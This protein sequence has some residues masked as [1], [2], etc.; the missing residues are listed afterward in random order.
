MK[1]SELIP[2]GERKA[3]VVKSKLTY[4]PQ[5]QAIQFADGEI[6]NWVSQEKIDFVKKNG[7]LYAGM[8]VHSTHKSWLMNNYEKDCVIAYL[9]SKFITIM[10][11]KARG[12]KVKIAV[13]IPYRKIGI[14]CGYTTFEWNFVSDD[15]EDNPIMKYQEEL[16]IVDKENWELYLKNKILEK[17]E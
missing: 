11:L 14:W 6:D 17:L 3:K 2:A 8:N 9:K 16:T 7:F 12:N 1:I 13:H 15:D 5:Q 4:R 10:L